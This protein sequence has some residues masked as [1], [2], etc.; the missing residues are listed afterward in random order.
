MG[1]LTTH[2]LD[3]FNGCP[4]A[5]MTIQLWRM[6]DENEGRTQ[7]LTITTDVD[8]RAGTP[9][10]DDDAL[11]IGDY[12]LVFWVRDYFQAKGHTS[13]FLKR[14]PILFTIFDNTQDYHIPLLVSPWAYSTY[15]GS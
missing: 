9:L 5:G 11:Q 15:R 12:E 1:K 3:T 8:G 6:D 4:A 13:P 10:L 2:V 7:L 14:V